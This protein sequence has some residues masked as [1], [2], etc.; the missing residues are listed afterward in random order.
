MEE[1]L[2]SDPLPGLHVGLT[3]NLKKGIAGESADSEAEFDQ[4][5]TIDAIKNAL[6]EA[7]CQ[8][9]M[10]EADLSLPEALR[11]QPLDIV[12][13]IAE[14]HNGRGREAQVP[15]LLNFFGI[16]FVGSDETTLCIALDKALTKRI[17]A[18]YGIKTPAGRL[19][20]AG[21]FRLAGPVRFPAI[22][23]PNAEGSSKGISDQA[24]VQ[25]RTALQALLE[26]NFQLY[27][28]DMLVES[29]IEGRE[30]PVGLLGNGPDLHV[31]RPMEVV[32][33]QPGT[34]FAAYNYTVK[35][36]W[37]QLVRYACPA[38]LEPAA[39]ARMVADARTIFNRLN[40][41][42][43]ARIDFRLDANGVP[44]FIEINPLPGL[45]PGYSDYPMLA[46]FNGMAYPDLIRGILRAAL[47][48]MRFGEVTRYAA[49]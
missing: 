46:G 37:Q 18:T 20:P 44:W 30:F 36:N 35:Q 9:A 33:L 27:G 40:C 34:R 17:L 32:W 5:E 6:Q 43:F 29:F 49:T 25:D 23:K 41:R 3:F 4:P 8:V 1:T 24:V 10:L 39:E 12:F 22:V 19:V 31:F 21:Q 11:A 7:G 47:Q 26:R 16:P 38:N 42:D 13:N 45:A 15:A 28:Q 48:R 14:G 2:D